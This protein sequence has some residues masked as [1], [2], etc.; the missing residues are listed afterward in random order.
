MEASLTSTQKVKTVKLGLTILISLPGI[1]QG[2]LSGKGLQTPV[3]TEWPGPFWAQLQLH[4][5]EQAWCFEFCPEPS[6]SQYPGAQ[7]WDPCVIRNQGP[8]TEEACQTSKEP[9]A[10]PTP[11][12]LGLSPSSAGTLNMFHELLEPPFPYLKTCN[13]D[14]KT[15]FTESCED[16]SPTW[17]VSGTMFRT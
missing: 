15:S 9:A 11:L 14:N 7:A 12:P 16:H 17:R 5:T 4:K 1:T 10:W 3:S 8:E 2:M 13:D 6:K